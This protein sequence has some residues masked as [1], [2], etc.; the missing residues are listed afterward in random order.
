M[1]GNERVCALCEST[2]VPSYA[3][4]K[5]CG[6]TCGHTARYGTAPGA[7]HRG[8]ICETC[9][10]VYC[11]SY[12]QQRTCGRACGVALRRTMRVSA[13]CRQCGGIFETSLAGSIPLTCGPECPAAIPKDATVPCGVCGISFSSPSGAMLCSAACR[14]ER[15][16]Q[17][18]RAYNQRRR[19]RWNCPGC[20]LCLTG[21]RQKCDACRD[22]AER[23]RKRRGKR[24]R[25]A[26][27][28]GVTHE[29][30][31]L[32]E[33]ATRDRY[34]CGL[35][36]KRVA[37]KQVV[38]HPKAPTIDHI[39]PIAAGGDDTRAN[40]QLAHFECNWKK[41][42]GGTQQLVLFG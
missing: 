11:A 27:K 32:T 37:M 23:E 18:D 10:K 6:T 40:V 21:Q 22:T 7:P 41:S 12:P 1:V 5:Y 4:Q 34:R 20:G 30:Y 15:K 38:P 14:A 35:C 42:D 2:Y 8:R 28:R 16:R 3:K 13:T 29:P 24:K 25:R 9:G 39:L 36:R 19:R 26:L 33:I 31:T 17:S